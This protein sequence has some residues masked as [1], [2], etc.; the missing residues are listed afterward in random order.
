MNDGPLSLSETRELLARLAHMPKKWLGQNFLVDGNIVRKSLELG[1]VKAGDTV[2]EVGPGLGTLTRTLLGAGVNL[3][4][5]EADRTMVYHLET[6]L[7]PRHPA[8]FHLHEGD[9]VDFPRAGLTDAT[10][11]SFKVI[12][13]LP[14]AIS[15]PWMDAICAGPHPSLMVLML[16]REAADRLTAEVGTGHWSA[17]TAQVRL[18]FERVKVHPVPAQSFNPPPKVDS[19][20]LVLR[21]RADARRLSPRAREVARLLFTQRR[22]QV[23]SAARKLFPDQADVTRWLGALPAFG[24]TSLARPET[25]PA[26]AWLTL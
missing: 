24:V 13:N 16:Q 18:A 9:A 20:L 6:T 14:Y 2:V 21:R 22:K 25:I 17:V 26:E 4:A 11:G 7:K 10:D 1:E 3:F 15:T 5:V 23:G 19:C 12:A 8:T